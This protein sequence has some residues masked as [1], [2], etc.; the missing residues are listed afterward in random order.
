MAQQAGL[1]QTAVDVRDAAAAA[2]GRAEAPAGSAS[3]VTS[4]L[5]DHAR[6]LSYHRL[7]Q[8]PRVAGEERKHL[9]HRIV[10]DLSVHSLAEGEVLY[11]AL[12]NGLGPERRDRVLDDPVSLK[13]IIGGIDKITADDPGFT[14]R[15]DD[16]YREL[17]AHVD[18]EENSVLPMFAAMVDPSELDRLGRRFEAAKSRVPTRPDTLAPDKPVTGNVVADRLTAPL[19]KMRDAAAG[20]DV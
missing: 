3:I 13:I 11:P 18:E 14:A 20:R 9:R 16:L 12:K 15:I 6:L 4:I 10:H 8:G 1:Y 5:D 7:L 19:D 17:R 2:G